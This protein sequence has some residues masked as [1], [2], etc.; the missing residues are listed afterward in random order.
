MKQSRCE[1]HPICRKRQCCFDFEVRDACKRGCFFQARN[2]MEKPAFGKLNA[3]CGS[4]RA[5]FCTIYKTQN[6]K[7]KRTGF[8][9]ARSLFFCRGRGAV[10]GLPV[11]MRGG[12]SPFGRKAV[13]GAGP[14]KKAAPA[15]AFC[16]EW[17][18]GAKNMAAVFPK[19][20]GRG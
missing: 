11:V 16:I 7:R 12:V 4:R 6:I 14:R 17:R 8:D 9:G 1:F 2:A 3:L 15:P 13:G 19:R 18:P 5:T 20:A 10:G